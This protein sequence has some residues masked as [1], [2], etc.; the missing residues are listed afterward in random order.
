MNNIPSLF[1]EPSDTEEPGRP[2]LAPGKLFLVCYVSERDT[3]ITT[4][5]QGK[6]AAIED[7]DRNARHMLQ[8]RQKFFS[9]SQQQEC[10]LVIE[11]PV[12][13]VAKV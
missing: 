3:H 6:E 10:Y 12:V 8:H 1:Q 9:H 5:H 11:C 13:H 7:A 2:T 4:I